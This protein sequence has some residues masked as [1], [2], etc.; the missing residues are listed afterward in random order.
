VNRLTAEYRQPQMTPI[1]AMAKEVKAPAKNGEPVVQM[2]V[3]V[4]TGYVS[5]GQANN[6]ANP[7][8]I[9]PKWSSGFWQIVLIAPAQDAVQESNI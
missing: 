7:Q 6:N 1:P 5:Y 2:V 3:F 9:S 8:T 4:E